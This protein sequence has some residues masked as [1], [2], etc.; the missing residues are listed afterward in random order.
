[1][2]IKNM[3]NNYF[4]NNIF[5]KLED[6]I[7]TCNSAFLSDLICDVADNDYEKELLYKNL[8]KVFTNVAYKM[9]NRND[10][11]LN[12]DVCGDVN[13]LLV[14]M[15]VLSPDYDVRPVVD[16]I[17]DLVDHYKNIDMCRELED[18]IIDLKSGRLSDLI[19]EVAFYNV[20][21]Y[22]D[23]LF[24]A[25]KDLYHEGYYDKVI[26]ELGGRGNILGD[27]RTA[28]YFKNNDICFKNQTRIITNVAF[29]KFFDAKIVIDDNVK[30]NTIYEKIKYLDFYDSVDTILDEIDNLI[31]NYKDLKRI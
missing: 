4:D 15:D 3:E 28:Q 16:E 12:Y 13:K 19:D 6:R 9:F 18:K 17:E 8:K 23:D 29:R 25:L 10:I 22:T 14:D 11:D 20:D 2:K 5:D 24:E 21:M 26:G 30:Y 7:I 1:M 27:I 31:D